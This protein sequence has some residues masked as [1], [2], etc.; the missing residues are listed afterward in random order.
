MSVIGTPVVAANIV[1]GSN[2]AVKV[3]IGSTV[4]T[5]IMEGASEKE[6]SGEVLSIEL[7]NKPFYGQRDRS[8]YD[9]IP[10]SEYNDP[11]QAMIANAADVMEVSA[12]LL[13]VEGDEPD[14]VVHVR[15]PVG[16]IKTISVG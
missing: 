12:L 3:E 11:V 1:A 16:R 4:T 5:T 9:G 2:P 7:N 13:G 10:T 8:V 15:I 14:T 6:Y